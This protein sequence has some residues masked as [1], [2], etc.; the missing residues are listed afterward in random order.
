[1]LFVLAATSRAMRT[2]AASELR[3]RH[4]DHLK[5]FFPHPP[6]FLA[7]LRQFNA[8]VAGSVALAYFEGVTESWSPNECNIYL[9]CDKYEDFLNYVQFHEGYVIDASDEARAKV[10]GMVTGLQWVR[11]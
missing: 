4:H 6:R 5:G 1:M 2:L 10:A 3:Q 8:I 9:P 7:A 11:G